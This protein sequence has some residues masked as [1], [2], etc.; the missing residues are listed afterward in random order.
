[1]GPSRQNTKKGVNRRCKQSF[2]VPPPGIEG[3]GECDAST[4]DGASLQPCTR[5]KSLQAVLHSCCRQSPQGSAGAINGG[6]WRNGKPCATCCKSM[7]DMQQSDMVKR[8][9]SLK[10]WQVGN[11][12][13]LRR[14]WNRSDPIIQFLL[15]CK[16]LL[17][18]D[19]QVAELTTFLWMT[20]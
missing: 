3:T 14:K 9:S 1:M 18:L 19:S 10:R 5:V 11:Y 20:F 7:Q 13:K 12:S 16:H 15:F 6:E 2:P 4:G 17:P 8:C